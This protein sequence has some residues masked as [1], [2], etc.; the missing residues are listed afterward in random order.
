MR[1]RTAA[2]ACGQLAVVCLGEP[3]KVSLCHCLDC[4]RRTGSTYGVAAFYLRNEATAQGR[5]NTF[6]RSSDG[7]HA[8]T[9]HFC[10][11]C[12]STVYW[13]PERKPETIAVAVGSFADPSFPAPTQSVW[14][15]RRH[16]WVPLST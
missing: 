14:E 11:D 13:E 10:P 8:I 16:S 7:G 12:G 2:C 3:H 9:F 6:E 4:Q 15:E 1:T 5:A